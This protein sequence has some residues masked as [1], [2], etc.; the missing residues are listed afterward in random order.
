MMDITVLKSSI[1]S[2]TVPKF[3]IFYVEEPALYKQYK[4][5]IGN[6]VGLDYEVYLT[7]KE[8]IY[9]IESNIKDNHIYL[10]LDDVGVDSES[11]EK[12][13]KYGKNVILCYNSKK[14]DIPKKAFQVLEKY[15]SYSVS[16]E[17]TDKNTLLA[18]AIK[19]CKKNKCAIEQELL[20]KLIE[21]CNCDLGILVNELDKI[22]TLEQ[23]NSNVLASYMINNGFID[24]R[25]ISMWG[26]INSFINKE[27]DC[28]Y[29]ST[30]LSDS[31]VTL[32]T[33]IYNTALQKLKT[34]RLIQYSKL[35]KMCFNIQKG[36]LDGIL[37][38]RYAIKY[39]M[40]WW[41]K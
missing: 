9:D 15:D 5:S 10:V 20:I 18:Y 30:R 1:F 39:L 33:C 34:T 25:D 17:K 16:F 19:L 28:V 8:A 32:L 7:V 14:S 21:C 4:T 36:I 23:S 31:P 37:D 12:L 13:L 38:S 6:T 2:N 29:M 41:I 40:M 22:F 3:M 27:K 24:Y 26:F 11:I 35:M